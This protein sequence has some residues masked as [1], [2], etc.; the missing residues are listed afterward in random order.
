MLFNCSYET[1]CYFPKSFAKI[2]TTH[3]N[4]NIAF[5]S[6]PGPLLEMMV[7][8]IMQKPLPIV[9]MKYFVVTFFQ[10]S[11]ADIHHELV[12]RQALFSVLFTC[13]DTSNPSSF[14]MHAVSK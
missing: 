4:G 14:P 7:F 3:I 8:P 13:L 1:I 5:I 2:F 11:I 9:K 10:I 6:F 12:T